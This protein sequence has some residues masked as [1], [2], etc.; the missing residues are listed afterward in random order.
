MKSESPIKKHHF[1][2]LL[3][4]VPLLTLIGVLMISG[5][6][7][8]EIAKR[9][10]DLK[11]ANDKIQSKMNP[12]T[13]ALIAET[14]KV[15]GQVSKRQGGLHEENWTRQKHLFTW[16]TNSKLLKEYEKA[17]Y[18]FGDPL[19][20]AKGEFDEFRARGNE[21]YLPEFSTLL[22]KDAVGPGTGMADKVAPTT[23]RGG[24]QSVL[25]HVNDWGGSQLTKDQVWLIMEDIWIQ[26]SLLEAITTVNAEVAA[27]RRAVRND[28]TGAL[29]PDTSF[30][31]DGFKLDKANKRVST[32]DE[33][34]TK[35]L[36]A[37]RTW[38]LDLEL[39]KE[40][41]DLFLG[42]TLTNLTERLQLMGTNNMMTL[43]VWFSKD[44]AAQPM[45]FRIGG[46]YL[47]GVGSVRTDRIE[48]SPGKFEEKT[49]PGNVLK[50]VR[51]PDLHRVPATL[52]ATEI[53]RVE[54]VLDVRT[55]P[56]KRIDALELGK[57][58]SRY[59]AMQLVTPSFI[60][61]EAKP[62]AGGDT[63]GGPGG[64]PMGTPGGGPGAPPMPGGGPGA[65]PGPGG[66]PGSGGPGGGSGAG[67]LSGGGSV[68]TVIDGNRK[69]YLPDAGAVTG[70]PPSVRRM[71]VAVVVV[72]DQAH[73]Q[74]IL[75]AFANSPLRFQITQVT[76]RRY[77]GNDLTNPNAATSAG[78]DDDINFGTGRNNITGS[79]DPDSRPGG[80]PPPMP[81]GGPPPMGGPGPVPSGPGPGGSPPGPGGSPPGPGSSGG[82]TPPSTVSDAQ[83]TSGLVVLNVYGIISIYEKFDAPKDGTKTD[84]KPDPKVDPKPDPKV[85]PKVDPKGGT[86]VDP[87]PDPK[88]PPPGPGPAPMPKDTEPAKMRRRARAPR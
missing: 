64:T 35:A 22:K 59:A 8:G 72:V 27:Y 84:P 51:V 30:D 63:G 76:W 6:V 21:V 77:R 5:R 49:G 74:D 41:N 48:V 67:Q 13:N 88:M 25:R 69:R 85:D 38:A 16:P 26:R 54:Q 47:Q 11:A 56:V 31:E 81:M 82:S 34:K 79:S 23:F 78:G 87:K 9:K 43:R 66:P 75:L 60:K 32:P 83:V 46:E 58:D 45:L 15:V 44:K 3:G 40:G 50:I 18:K 86:K 36:F 73:M 55:V 70:Q 2:L 62:P 19:P 14:E 80:S 10:A 24:W 68:A 37:N 52:N 28:K 61:E 57:L 20:T 17:N 71:P 4:V 12:K 7:G 65:P 53:V 29:S 42:G 1:W 33:E 39:V